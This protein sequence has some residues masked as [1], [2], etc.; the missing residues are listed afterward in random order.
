MGNFHR[1]S[2]GRQGMCEGHFRNKQRGKR[3]SG[4]KN[5]K[6]NR[7]IKKTLLKEVGLFLGV[8]REGG[9]GGLFPAGEGNEAIFP[10]TITGA[11]AGE[12]GSRAGE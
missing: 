4:E 7:M 8:L 10:E 5:D 1:E 3:D 11:Q 6:K 2:G 12:K 9:V